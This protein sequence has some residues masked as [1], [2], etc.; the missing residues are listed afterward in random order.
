MKLNL[1]VSI[2]GICAFIQIQKQLGITAQVYEMNKDV[3]G[4][5][6][7]NTYPN[8]RCDVTSHMYSFSFEMNPSRWTL[9]ADCI[10]I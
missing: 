10:V 4:T 6:L 1:L 3:G 7:N 2:S 5:W 8:C 9:D